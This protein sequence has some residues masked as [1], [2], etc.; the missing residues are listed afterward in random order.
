MLTSLTFPG[1]DLVILGIFAFLVGLI[2]M[3]L[4]IKIKATLANHSRE[5]NDAIVEAIVSEYTH[6]LRD[7]DKVISE[8]QAKL[9]I[10]EDRLQSQGIPSQYTSQ[11]RPHVA[12][13]AEPVTITQGPIVENEVNSTT[14]Y[15]LKLLIE[16]SR[17]SR[18]VQLAIGRTREH[19]ARLMKKLHDLGL[20]SRD[21]NSKP[22]RYNITTAGRETLAKRVGT[23]SV[24]V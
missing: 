6:K 17:T 19:T 23:A 16:R 9:S 22:F 15:I 5:S 11:V 12:Q 21:I 24:V 4:Y 10:L 2:S 3:T 1:S 18:E 8:L 7:Y 20:I 14:D 13:A